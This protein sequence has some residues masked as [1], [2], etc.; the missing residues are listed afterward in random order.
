MSKPSQVIVVVE[1][2]R[3]QALIR[4]Y[5]KS[6]GLNEHQ[7]RFSRSPSGRGSAESWVRKKFVDETK[8][9]RTRHARTELVV[10]IDADTSTVQDRY[11]QLDRALTESGNGIVGKAERIARLVPKRN[12][13]TWIL[14]LNQEIVDEN[15]DYKTTRI[16][17]SRLIPAA[18]NTLHEWSRSKADPPGN[19]VSSLLTGVRELK[20]LM[21]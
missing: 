1:D 10:M 17:W 4:R 11:N 16:S 2:G 13:E 15:A 14:C 8:V 20:R 21:L 18:G 6:R 12:V 9:Y 3:Q 19:C 5:L 7:M